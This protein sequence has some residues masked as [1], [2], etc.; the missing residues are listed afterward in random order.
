MMERD[1]NVVL[2][3]DV[4]RCVPSKP[5]PAASS[6]ARAKAPIPTHFASLADFALTAPFVPPFGCAEFMAIEWRK[7]R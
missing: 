7:R 2:A 4:T 1:P 3:D 5:C 6:C